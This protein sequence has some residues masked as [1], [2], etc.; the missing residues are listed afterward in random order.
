MVPSIITPPP[1][2]AGGPISPSSIC[3][4]HVDIPELADGRWIRLPEALFSS[5]MAVEPDVNPMYKTSKA[6]SDAWLKDALRMNDKTASIWSRLDIA[7]MSAICAPNADLETLKLMNDWNGWV[8]AFDDPF[9]EGS[10]ANNPI[11]AAEEVIY[12]LA[13]LDNIHPVVSPDQNP[14]RHTLQSCWNRFRQR[15]SPALQYR[16]KKHLTMYCIGV[17][18]QVGVQNTASRLSVEEYM[19]MRAGCVG[20]YPCI[21]L[22]EFAEGIDLPQDVMDHPSLEA[23]SRITCDLV[24][25]QNDLCSYRK[26]LIQGEDSNIMFILRDQGMTDQEAADE[27][28]EMLYDCYRRW[29]TAMANLPFW[30]EGVDRDVIKFVNGCRNIAL[31]NLHWS[32]YTFRYLGDEGP[33]VKKTRM[34]RLP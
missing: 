31:G 25:L 9:D 33:Q 2:C 26:D 4:D 30:G 19:D 34:M 11:K 17:L 1:S 18:Q 14:L 22:M 21:G 24:T 10:F 15:A 20:A 7:Y 23:I 6:L 16:W 13:T 3:S 12:T 5:I 27:I 8:F 28:G 32:L 29:H